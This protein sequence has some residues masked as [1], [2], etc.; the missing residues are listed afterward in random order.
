MD[1]VELSRKAKVLSHHFSGLK[2]TKKPSFTDYLLTL[3]RF[4]QKSVDALYS[5]RCNEQR[6]VSLR[7]TRTLIVTIPAGVHLGKDRK[8]DMNIPDR[9]AL[10]CVLF[11]FS[12]IDLA[13][14][15]WELQ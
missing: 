15:T 4:T 7:V 8:G 3:T 12:I 1:K 11:A 13:V 6:E 2:N 9:L 5:N 14:S 10:N